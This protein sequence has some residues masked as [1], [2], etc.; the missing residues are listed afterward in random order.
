MGKTHSTRTA[1]SERL[2]LDGGP[3]AKRHPYA[4]GKKHSLAEYSAIRRIFERGEIAMTRGPEVM[5]L[6]RRFAKLYGAKYCAT[7]SSG[8]AAIHAALFAVGV[9][10]GDEVIT[11]PFT[12]MGTFVG[13]L[14]QNAVP[15]FAD[16]D[17]AK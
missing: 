4:T 6:R 7:A 10:R 2:A 13:I 12:D 9:G 11:T 17:P 5:E 3:R 14:A 8:T 1:S 16:V 15:V